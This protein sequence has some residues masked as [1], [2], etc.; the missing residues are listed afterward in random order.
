MTFVDPPDRTP[1]QLFATELG[2]LRAML[3]HDAVP[4]DLVLAQTRKV[5]R[6]AYAADLSLPLLVEALASVVAADARDVRTLP[7]ELMEAGTMAYQALANRPTG[8]LLD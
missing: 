8:V 5:A 7:G 1:W 2:R 6:G 4:S 3:R